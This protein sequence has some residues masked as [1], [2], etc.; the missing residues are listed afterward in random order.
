MMILL[1]SVLSCGRLHPFHLSLYGKYK[2]RRFGEYIYILFDVKEVALKSASLTAV[3][4]LKLSSG[5]DVDLDEL[6]DGLSIDVSVKV[7][8][9][10]IRHLQKGDLRGGRDTEVIGIQIA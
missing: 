6:V 4:R 5:A 2:Y 8:L 10:L 3:S 9:S 1:L 7:E